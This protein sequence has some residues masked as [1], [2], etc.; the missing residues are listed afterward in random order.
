MQVSDGNDSDTA[1]LS[2]TVTNVVELTAVSG[3]AAVSHPENWPGRVATY[4]ASSEADA[5]GISWSLSG[6]DASSFAID[7]PGG[8]LRFNLAVPSGQLWSPPPDFETPGDADSDGV[9]EV[10]VRAAVGSTTQSLAVQVTVGDEPES[11]T[12][13]LSTT[14]PALGDTVTATLAD[15]DGVTGAASYAWERST[16][17]GRWETLSGAAAASYTTVAA[18]SGRFLRVTATYSD[19]LGG[20]TATAETKEVV[21]AEMLSALA[22]STTDSAANTVRA[23]KPSFDPGVLHYSVG[24]AAAGD[25]MTLTPTAAPGVRL[26]IDGIQV[27]SGKPHEVAV[28]EHSEIR[29]TLANAAGAATD[30]FVRCT[31]GFGLLETTIETAPGATGVMQDLLLLGGC[32]RVA[33]M[34]LNGAVRWYRSDTTRNCGYFRSMWVSAAGDGGSGAYRYLYSAG[35]RGGTQVEWQILGENLETLDAAATVAPLKATDYHDA[36]VLDDG[37]YMLIA[38]EP[39]V[40]DLSGV[41]FQGRNNNREA[42]TYGAQET[43]RDSVIQIRNPAGASQFVWNSWDAIP[44][45]DCKPNVPPHTR[46][47]DYAHINTV[48]VVDGGDIVASL[49]GCS[50]VLRIDPDAAGAHKVVWRVGLSNLDDDQWAAADKGPAPLRFVGDAEG[51]FCAQHGSALLPGERLLLFDNGV[52]CMPDPW[53]DELLVDRTGVYSRAVEYALDHENGEAVFVR[54]HSLGG[55]RT[56]VGQFHGH[57]ETLPGGDWLVS[58]GGWTG[59]FGSI[60]LEAGHYPPESA[61]D[62]SITQV[63]PDTGEEKL[64]ITLS[65]SAGAPST[66]ALPLSPTILAPPAPALEA[67]VITG[68]HTSAHHTGAADRPTVAVAFSRPVPDFTA[69]ASATVTGAS[70]GSIAPLLEAGAPAHAYVFTLMPDGDGPIAFSLQADQA[71]AGT[72]AGVCAADGTRLTAVPT[73]SHDIEP[74]PAPAKPTGLAAATAGDARVWLSW[75][76][77]DNGTITGYEYQ[78]QTQTAG[79]WPAWGNSW[80]AMSGSSSS[81]TS[82][83]VPGLINGTEYRFRIRAANAAGGRRPV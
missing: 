32:R 23:L 79:S 27:V 55:T 29:I 56:K 14:R 33:I 45:E 30:Y 47:N 7:D 71:C 1:A 66:R 74:L 76:D 44:F 37:N 81:T 54:D 25:T 31:L 50:Q 35:G 13:A 22:V 67:T 60:S 68:D 26:S 62:K 28:A 82:H 21:T 65:N 42:H 24:C 43:V 63:D 49:R 80:T 73:L 16:G 78:Q 59:N 64:T 41:T 2:V 10:T 75:A 3:K 6:D 12:L 83:A 17:F 11:G 52:E 77:P 61:P 69:T 53:T 5:A 46:W 9:Y 51:Q 8:A 34:D 38:Y 15:P 18:D 4:S 39:A 36:L 58:W 19:G 20:S 48:Q 40:R 57:A 72:P 70:V